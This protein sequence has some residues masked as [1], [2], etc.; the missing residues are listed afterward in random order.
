MSIGTGIR[1]IIS[2]LLA[3]LLALLLALG[4]VTPVALAEPPVQTPGVPTDLS[5]RELGALAPYKGMVSVAHPLA[6]RAGAE[7]LEKGGNAIDAAAAIQFALNVEEPMMTGI[8][9]GCFIM[10][11]SAN[12]KK[13]YV[14]DGRERSPLGLLADPFPVIVGPKSG[15]S[16]GVP[17]TLLATAT[18]IERFGTM[19]LSEVMAPAI[20]MAEEGIPVSNWLMGNLGSSS[21]AKLN[22]TPGNAY[23]F[24]KSDGSAAV[25]AG[26][27]LIQPDLAKTFKMIAE[28]GTDVFYKGEIAD[29]IAAIVQARGG[30]MKKSDLESYTVSWREPVRGSYRGWE[31]VSMPPPSSGGL[32]VIQTL[33]MLEKFPLGQWGHNSEKTLHTVIDAIRVAW[34]DRGRYMADLDFVAMPMQGLLDP[35][36]VASRASLIDPDGPAMEPPTYGT[37][38]GPWVGGTSSTL[39][40][41]GPE[42]EAVESGETT[43]F[44]AADR[45]GNVVTWTTTIESVWGSG[46]MVPG[47]GF[48]LNN[49]MT[50]FDPGTTAANRIETG[51]P[52]RPR[53]SM[54]PTLLFKDGKPWMATGSPGGATIIN[55][56]LQVIM[57]VVD[58]GM[59]I[60]QAVLAP[61]ISQTSTGKGTT[62]WE[63][64]TAWGKGVSP[65]V[66][67][68]L[69]ARGHIFS[70]NPTT[71]GSA[72]SLVID[73]QTG[74]M[75]GAGDPRREGTLIA[76]KAGRSE[77]P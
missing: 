30:Y 40:L 64:D 31:I 11:Y 20:K 34:A 37:P 57:N 58:H 41:A 5:G 76:V 1:K 19:K 25:E 72:Q 45:W 24:V 68:A 29:A 60:E 13:T 51:K 70:S 21:L 12:D 9:G 15:T 39:A 47:Y 59:T 49:E 67:A 52:K 55:T 3:T 42:E 62:S 63:G 71:I 66:I 23:T 10:I 35:G 61:R 56:V 77:A 48:M 17:G 75:F 65:D 46:I 7:I 53:S 50:D 14:I 54:T 18:A 73:L 36:Y 2:L 16:V 32:T 28:Q 4:L 38:P 22:Y 8:G 74:R 33:E 6:A 43:H 69:K 27:I 44:V 26:K